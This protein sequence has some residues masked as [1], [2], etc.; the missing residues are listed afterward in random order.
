MLNKKFN[1]YDLAEITSV[2]TIGARSAA[3][4]LVENM[5]SINKLHDFIK[6]L[7]ELDNNQIL[8]RTLQMEGYDYFLQQFTHTGYFYD[9]TKRKVLPIKT[10]SKEMSNWGALKD[11]KSYPIT[12]ISVDIVANSRLVNKHGDKVMKKV[13]TN[14]WKFLR[15]SLSHTDGRIWTWAGDGGI[16]AFAFKDQ[17]ERAVKFSVEVQRTITLFNMEKHNPIQ[18]YIELRLGINTGKLVYHNDTGQIISEVINLAAHLEKNKTIPGGISVTEKVFTSINPKLQ[19]IFRGIGNF[20][21]VP[22]FQSERLDQI[23]C[24][25]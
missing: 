23:L 13:Y 2:V 9:F 14:L 5:E 21:G 24:L 3:T 10:E 19:S 7:A 17:I 8:G 6:L 1:L 4:V 15:N 12:I 11:G 20:E 22:C 16:L 18:D 25:D